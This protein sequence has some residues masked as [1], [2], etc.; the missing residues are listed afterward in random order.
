MNEVRGD[1][2]VVR[3]ALGL[4][5]SFQGSYYKALLMGHSGVGKSTELTRLIQRVE[6]KFCAIRTH[7]IFTIPVTQGRLSPQEEGGTI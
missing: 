7:L 2:R 5:R 6:D 3:F 1:D 4:N